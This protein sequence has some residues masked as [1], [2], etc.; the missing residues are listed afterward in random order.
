MKSSRRKNDKSDLTLDQIAEERAAGY[1]TRDE[2]IALVGGTI[3]SF[4][5]FAERRGIASRLRA[6]SRYYRVTDIR[7]VL[8]EQARESAKAAALARKAARAARKLT[9]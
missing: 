5:A 6:K 4:P 2:A 9:Q 8:D 3:N 1:I 7:S